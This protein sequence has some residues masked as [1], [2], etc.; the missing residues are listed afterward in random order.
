MK[1]SLRSFWNLVVIFFQKI[2]DHA[3]RIVMGIPTLQRSQIT[4]NLYLGGQYN[5]RGLRKL[6][7]MGITAIIN[8]RMHS[9]YAEA[10]YEGFRYLHLPTVDQTPP[11]LKDLIKG[12]G[13]AEEEIKNGGKVYIHCRQGHG[14]GPSMAIAYLLRI[15]TTFEDALALVKKVRTFIRPTPAQLDRLRELETFFKT[16]KAPA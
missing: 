4:A 13:F 11:A 15:G 8:M 16:E 1:T 2:F 7:E 14:R 3:Y 10:R 9:I 6:K 12:A 5:L